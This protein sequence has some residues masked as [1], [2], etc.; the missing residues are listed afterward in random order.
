[1]K[2][3]SQIIWAC[4]ALIAQSIQLHSIRIEGENEFTSGK[5]PVE[6]IANKAEKSAILAIESKEYRTKR[7][8]V[9]VPGS[10][11]SES[12]DPRSL[13]SSENPGSLKEAGVSFP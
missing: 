9:Q 6:S 5:K 13:D 1:M 3:K 8:A 11:R 4:L 2:T 10:V 7:P 12:S